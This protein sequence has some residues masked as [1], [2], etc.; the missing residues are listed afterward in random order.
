[1]NFFNKSKFKRR[2]N[3][4]AGKSQLGLQAGNA[5]LANFSSGIPTAKDENILVQDCLDIIDRQTAEINELKH[6]LNVNGSALDD[7]LMQTNVASYK[8]ERL[9][10]ELQLT[11]QEITQLRDQVKLLS[12]L[13][14]E[15]D[16]RE[17]EMIKNIKSLHR[18]QMSDTIRNSN[19]RIEALRTEHEKK[20]REAV[21]TFSQ[22]I[23]TLETELARKG[24]EAVRVNDQ[25]DVERSE[26][27]RAQQVVEELGEQLSQKG[28]RIH[29]LDSQM[30][31]QTDTLEQTRLSLN[32]TRNELNQERQRAGQAVR[33][34][35]TKTQQLEFVQQQC[36]SLQ[37]QLRSRN[38]GNCN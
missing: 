17:V 15:Q 31:T 26:R 3:Q 2:E 16:A 4:N 11:N 33:E 19:R 25:L 32:R 1:M 35:A 38:T 9:N 37:E 10:N 23:G 20:E 5:S 6:Q 21:K 13:A 36:A 14:G 28:E 18:A 24:R 8:E 12:Q 22:Q 27:A 34:C 30:Q 7:C 29:E